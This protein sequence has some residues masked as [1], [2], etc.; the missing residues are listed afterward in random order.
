[1]YQAGTSQ[2]HT[3]KDNRRGDDAA[4]QPDNDAKASRRDSAEAS[5]RRDSAKWENRPESA[6]D[7][8]RESS[9]RDTRRD[10]PGGKV[11]R[12]EDN[13][14]RHLPIY[15]DRDLRQLARAHDKKPERDSQQPTRSSFTVTSYD[16]SYEPKRKVTQLFV[17]MC[18]VVCN[19]AFTQGPNVAW[20]DYGVVNTERKRSEV[21]SLCIPGAQCSVRGEIWGETARLV[22]Q[23][24]R[25]T[26]S[27][28][29]SSLLLKLWALLE[30]GSVI[31]CH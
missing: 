2:A 29:S 12:D 28:L 25:Y 21:A 11:R 19:A 22:N 10:S 17:F 20:S 5:S 23:D 7:N 1:M 3:D 30:I 6:R 13:P 18:F 9:N 16:K 26:N 31:Q 27:S 15:D 24:R 14:Q 4:N 8:R